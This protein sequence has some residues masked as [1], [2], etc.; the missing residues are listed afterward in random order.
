[1]GVV[2][3]EMRERRAIVETRKKINFFLQKSERIVSVGGQNENY[4]YFS[5]WTMDD[6]AW[7]QCEWQPISE[8]YKLPEA[9]TQKIQVKE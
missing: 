1:M 6:R 2:V 8:R 5:Q 3:V 4:K 7:R 9:E